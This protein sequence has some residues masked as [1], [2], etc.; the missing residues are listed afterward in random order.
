MINFID[1]GA[2]GKLPQPWKRKYINYL[3]LCDA[4]VK[5]LKSGKC[6]VFK[7]CIYNDDKVR[8]FYTY[9]KIDT[10]S[11][12]KPNLQLCREMKKSTEKFNVVSVKNVECIRLDTLLSDCEELYQFIKCDTQG[13]D[14]AVLQ[15][16]GKYINEIIGVHCECFLS[17]MYI[18]VPLFRDICS[19]LGDHGIIPSRVIIKKPRTWADILFVRDEN[20]KTRKFIDKIY[21]KYEKYHPDILKSI[22]T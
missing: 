12:F 13:A 16:L 1:V 6:R 17:P 11:L 15:G 22:T 10:S 9:R 4:G 5:M 8:P 20:S 2:R 14:L 19:F 7:K 3:M 21:S 18:G